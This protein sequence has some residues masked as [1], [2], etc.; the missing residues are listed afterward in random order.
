[1]M[2]A[3]SARVELSTFEFRGREVQGLACHWEGGQ[4]AA[5]IAPRGMVACG[6]FDPAVCERFGFA[7]AMAHGTP[8]HPLV[9]PEDVLDAVIDTVS[10]RARELGVE[11]GMRGRDAVERLLD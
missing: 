10:T 4:Y 8:E 6:I 11:P 3:R 9:T 1:M 5:L 7:V 2:G